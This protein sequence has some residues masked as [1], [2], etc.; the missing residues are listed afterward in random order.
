MSYNKILPTTAILLLASCSYTPETHIPQTDWHNIPLPETLRA[1]SQWL[2]LQDVSDSF[3]Y[4]AKS[5]EFYDKWHDNH[6][7]GWKGPGAT[8]F[9]ASHSNLIDGKLVLHASPVPDKEQGQTKN[10]GNFKSK[11]TI[12]T[13]FV[14]AKQNIEY[15]IFVEASMKISGLALASN[16]WMLSDDD[17]Y[18]IDVTETYGD[19]VHNAMQMSTNYHIFKRDPVTNDYLEDY[20]HK[21]KHT[22]TENKDLL[23]QDF[24]RFGF[25]WKNPKHMEFYL[26][27]KLVR[28]LSVDTDL[29][30]PDGH[31]FDRP[32]RLIFDMEDHVWR[33]QKGITPSTEQLN[34]KANNKMYVDWIRAY[35]PANATN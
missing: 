28:T 30:D 17:K 6:I 7:R 24:H 18:E 9:S 10:Y 15:P 22:T 11:K 19:T 16:F 27:G 13:G 8:Y 21:P 25:Y 12:Y 33:A 5:A 2:P 23:N 20:G 26:D 4:P 35:R 1:E 34:D 32:M 29:T 3:S 14:T 31:F